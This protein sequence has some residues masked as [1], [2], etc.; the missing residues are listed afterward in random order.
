MATN[1]WSNVGAERG[2]VLPLAAVALLDS[3]VVV[4]RGATP[5]LARV[6][7]EGSEKDGSW[8]CRSRTDP[9]RS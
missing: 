1:V 3:I 9:R 8:G 6:S 7:I 5:T 2:V 4:V